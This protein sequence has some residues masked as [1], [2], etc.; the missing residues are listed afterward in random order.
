MPSPTGI[1]SG[2]PSNTS[3]KE[4]NQPKNKLGTAATTHKGLTNIF[5]NLTEFHAWTHSCSP[6]QFM[7][8]YVPVMAMTEMAGESARSWLAPLSSV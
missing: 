6:S 3:P 4:R 7:S 2:N 8:R 5:R 1:A